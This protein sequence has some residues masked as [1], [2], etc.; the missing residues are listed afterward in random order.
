MDL[1]DLESV[2]I[3]WISLNQ[4][5][6]NHFRGIK[7]CAVFIRVA[8]TCSQARWKWPLRPRQ[9]TKAF[10][11]E[12]LGFKPKL[13]SCSWKS[14]ASVSRLFGPPQLSLPIK[15]NY[16]ALVGIE[17]LVRRLN[18]HRFTL[19]LNTSWILYSKMYLKCCKHVF[20]SSYKLQQIQALI[21]EC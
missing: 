13:A 18:Q 1:V 11:D 5:T 15:G 8:C 19:M 14:K 7:M 9:S 4:L 12:V 17:P 6:S 16:A 2:W 21:V 3:N 10:I 20:S